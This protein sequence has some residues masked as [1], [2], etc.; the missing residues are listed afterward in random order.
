MEIVALVQQDERFHRP[1]PPAL[2]PACAVDRNPVE[3]RS[4]QL[5]VMDLRAHLGRG[6]GIRWSGDDDP[7]GAAGPCEAPMITPPAMRVRVRN[8]L[9]FWV[10]LLICGCRLGD[11]DSSG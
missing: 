9:N 4:P 2:A 10:D 5:F 1:A 3:T 11:Y 6:A 7:C 8:R